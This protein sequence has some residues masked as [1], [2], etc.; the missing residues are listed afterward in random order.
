MGYLFLIGAI[1]AE[2]VSTS[3]LKLSV[4]FTK[5]VPSLIFLLGMGISFFLLSKTLTILPLSVAYAIWSG[6]GTALTTLVAILI[7]KEKLTTQMTIG[8]AL[9]V[10]GVVLL[11][12]KSTRI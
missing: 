12:M 6:I 4:G 7:W 2:V 8:I 5:F 11:N 9:I 1:L 10:I 3:M